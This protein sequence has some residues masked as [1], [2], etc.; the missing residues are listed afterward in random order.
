MCECISVCSCEP[1]LSN[2]CGVS[3]TVVADKLRLPIIIFL[4]DF[5][6][7]PLCVRE[8]ER[9]RERETKLCVRER[10]RET[11]LVANFYNLLFN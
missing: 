8:R 11:Q 1:V 5:A 4:N 2:D 6:T 10:E 3:L 7:V 9:V